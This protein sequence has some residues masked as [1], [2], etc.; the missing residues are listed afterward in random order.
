MAATT[1]LARIV[2]LQEL[3]DET[4]QQLADLL[5]RH[6]EARAIGQGWSGLP[7]D[8]ASLS[9]ALTTLDR[10]LAEKRGEL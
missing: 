6:R 5:Q 4:E 9:D 8:I 3:R 7:A 10:R 2:S 1:Y